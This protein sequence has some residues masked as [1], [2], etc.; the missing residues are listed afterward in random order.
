MATWAVQECEAVSYVTLTVLLTG[1][2]SGIP[3]TVT[4]ARAL[5]RFEIHIA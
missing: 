3:E 5:S 4:D 1:D 2:V